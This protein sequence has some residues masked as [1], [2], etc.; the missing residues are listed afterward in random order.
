[1]LYNFVVD[2]PF[3]QQGYGAQMLQAVTTHLA[4]LAHHQYLILYVQKTNTRAK[5]L[6][7][8]AHFVCL[9]DNPNDHTQDLY[10]KVLN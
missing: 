8:Q 1:V 2:T 9:G 4:S 5:K 3:R 6:Y 7:E 10:H